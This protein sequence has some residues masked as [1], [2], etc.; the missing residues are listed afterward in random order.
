MSK[1]KI[2]D[3]NTGTLTFEFK[4]EEWSKALDKS[5][6]KN[7]ANVKVDG[8]REGN[9]PR[10][11]FEKKY[12]VESLFQDAIDFLLEENYAEALKK[13]NVEPVSFPE[14]SI[15]DV[16]KDGV[17]INAIV[18]LPPEVKLASYDKM[19]IEVPVAKVTDE[20]IDKEIEAMR[21]QQAEMVIKDGAVEKGDTAVIDYKGMKDGVA[22]EGGTAE[23]H[24]LEIGSG[25]FI[26][27]FEDSVEGMKAGEEKDISL[28]FPEEYHSEELA[29]ADVVFNV[30]VNEVKKRV[31][32]ELTDEFAKET[33]FAAETVNELKDKV[34]ESMQTNFDA[35]KENSI[36]D[37]LLNKLA[38]E[39]EMNI[40]KQMI[41][42]EVSTMINDYSR[43][44][45]QQGLS[46]D[47][48]FQLTNTTEADLR[49]QL[50]E[51]ASKRVRQSLTLGKLIEDLK[52]EAN[53]K[54]I[55]E[56]LKK[57]SEL[58]GMDV[59]TIEK[60]IGGRSQLEYSIKARKA[61]DNLKSTAKVKEIEA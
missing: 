46:L 39:S 25:S 60:S 19:E 58:Y 33:S 55:D 38:E 48:Y 50:K 4:G 31:V 42:T 54:D 6:D 61:L 23:N 44:M 2:N 11:I 52:V 35:Q 26:P 17:K 27:G 34:K 56:E 29:G 45:Q 30:K 10:N 3:D 21:N 13:H 49:E 41:D 15:E 9:V 51:D 36:Y 32:P 16:S 59:E 20:L 18:A 40:P 1:W 43:N 47:Q 8:F 53:D 24:P 28:K 22:F 37:A 57:M 12:G 7:K 14:L 5:F